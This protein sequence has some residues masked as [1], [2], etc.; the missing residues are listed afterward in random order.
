MGLEFFKLFL[1]LVTPIQKMIQKM[2][3][4]GLLL[5]LGCYIIIWNIKLILIQKDKG[6]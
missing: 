2:I 3:Q 1:L 4:N 5:E 6:E